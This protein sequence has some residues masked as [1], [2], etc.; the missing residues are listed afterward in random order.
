VFLFLDCL[1]RRAAYPTDLSL[2]SGVAWV[3]LQ[4]VE[5]IAG[6]IRL[7]LFPVHVIVNIHLS[8]F[9]SS[10]PPRAKWIWSPARGLVGPRGSFSQL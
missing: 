4:S 1:T 10:E 9:I 8:S 3:A 7:V 5:D 6:Q 2:V